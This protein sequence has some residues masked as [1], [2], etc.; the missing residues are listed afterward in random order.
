M[1]RSFDGRGRR[2][3]RSPGRSAINTVTF[4]PAH[5]I[6]RAMAFFI[7]LTHGVTGPDE[8][9]YEMDVFTTPAYWCAIRL[10]R[11]VAA[12][13]CEPYLLPCPHT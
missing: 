12:E 4:T 6:P 1:W 7:K 11:E 2:L 8:V 3:G 10:G 5:K 13:G 9:L